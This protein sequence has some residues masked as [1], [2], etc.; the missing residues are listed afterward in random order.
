MDEKRLYQKDTGQ[1]VPTRQGATGS[2]HAIGWPLAVSV[3]T[4]AGAYVL[5]GVWPVGRR[6]RSRI[7]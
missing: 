5:L 2:P 4:S 7:N 1:P 3:V 6:S